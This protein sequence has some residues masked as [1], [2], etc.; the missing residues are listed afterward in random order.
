MSISDIELMEQGRY[1]HEVNL[2]VVLRL[3]GQFDEARKQVGA[4]QGRTGHW[5]SYWNGTWYGDVT[6][7][8]ANNLRMDT[9][10]LTFGYVH[11]MEGMYSDDEVQY[12]IC[13]MREII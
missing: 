3:R 8:T 9:G 7:S 4:F 2:L 11:F 13:R 1:Q 5:D 6:I 12:A 10:G